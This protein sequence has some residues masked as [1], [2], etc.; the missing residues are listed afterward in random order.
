MPGADSEINIE[1]DPALASVRNLFVQAVNNIDTQPMGVLL[2]FANV[3]RQAELQMAKQDKEV[4]ADDVVNAIAHVLS[5][6]N[7]SP[8]QQ[9]KIRQLVKGMQAAG[10]EWT[11]QELNVG[12]ASLF[13]FISQGLDDYCNSLG[14]PLSEEEEALLVADEATPQQFTQLLLK[15]KAQGISKHLLI[16]ELLR[17]RAQWVYLADSSAEEAER[18][19]AKALV[20]TIDK[21]LE[22]PNQ[23]SVDSLKTLAAV[24]ITDEV[25]RAIGFDVV[26]S[27]W[28]N[29]SISDEEKRL[30]QPFVP[31]ENQL[32]EARR[33]ALASEAMMQQFTGARGED[34]GKAESFFMLYDQEKFV[35][36]LME[37]ANDLYKYLAGYPYHADAVN[38][39]LEKVVINL[40][41]PTNSSLIDLLET[42]SDDA[43]RLAK[44]TQDESLMTI[45]GRL[46]EPC[47]NITPEHQ[48]FLRDNWVRLKSEVVKAVAVLSNPKAQPDR[49]RS[50]D[51]FKLYDEERFIDTLVGFTGNLCRYVI[52]HPNETITHNR[53]HIVSQLLGEINAVLEQREASPIVRLEYL[54][55]RAEALN[56]GKESKGELVEIINKLREKLDSVTSSQKDF[57]RNNW[58]KRPEIGQA[59]I[60]QKMLRVPIKVVQKHLDDKKESASW[61]KKLVHWVSEA[62][63]PSR[64]ELMDKVAAAAAA[65]PKEATYSK[66]FFNHHKNQSYFSEHMKSSSRTV[67]QKNPSINAEPSA[68]N[69]SL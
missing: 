52:N 1:V 34:E 10:G 11:S 12:E 56:L 62:F 31:S 19:A 5:S 38:K 2:A 32:V 22:T 20:K 60:E 21:L 33:L 36:F 4:G 16:N 37:L 39:I 43:S 23:L 59:E 57:L 61:I 3:L 49:D 48:A 17:L 30:L 54:L 26:K 66:T 45:V 40:R 55:K 51:F 50:E 65:K 67:S 27:K 25:A 41:N 24:S 29:V 13:Q 63:G 42:L 35:N 14:E 47:K 28:A 44:E 46:S 18:K 53:H 8:E 58:I 7:I 9:P 64:N 6:I 15:V 69:S 68:P